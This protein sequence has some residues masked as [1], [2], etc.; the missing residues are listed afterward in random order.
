MMRV[1]RH[2][3][4]KGA[5]GRSSHSIELRTP[6]KDFFEVLRLRFARTASATTSKAAKKRAQNAVY[7]NS[8]SR[9]NC[10]SRDS[11]A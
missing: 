3:S 11:A 8:G 5:F 4:G 7:R 1:G 6:T 9:T 10:N 2:A